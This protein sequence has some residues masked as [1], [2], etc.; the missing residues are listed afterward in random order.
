M[1]M[2]SSC[3]EAVRFLPSSDSDCALVSPPSEPEEPSEA[4]LEGAAVAGRS[5]GTAEGSEEALVSLSSSSRPP[6]YM[7]STLNTEA[8]GFALPDKFYGNNYVG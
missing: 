2:A 4:R 1:E 8:R 7:E 6:P 3:N 5:N